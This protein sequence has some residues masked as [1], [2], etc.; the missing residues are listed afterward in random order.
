MLARSHET[1]RVSSNVHAGRSDL[2]P[3]NPNGIRPKR[4]WLQVELHLLDVQLRAP[5]GLAYRH[6][7]EHDLPADAP[8]DQTPDPQ[9]RQ[10]ALEALLEPPARL[11]EAQAR[12]RVIIVEEECQSAG[13]AEQPER[14]PTTPTPPRHQNASPTLM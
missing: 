2:Q 13:N 9:P 5:A 11:L 14:G 3:I 8:A 4:A 12:V 6:I 10:G 1:R 7:G